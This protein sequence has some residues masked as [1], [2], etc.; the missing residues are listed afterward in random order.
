MRILVTI[1]ALLLL[2][3][4]A[5]PAPRPA[6]VSETSSPLRCSYGFG[7]S[8]EE[9]TLIDLDLVEIPVRDAV[10]AICDQAKR[11]YLVDDDVPASTRVTLHTRSVKLATALDVLTKL[12]GLQWAEETRDS[13]RLI[14]VG[15]NV[16][17]ASSY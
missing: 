10:K 15:K 4:V 6:R 9:D 2:T 3:S 13:K 5:Q 16:R 12:V 7:L 17:A 1:A 14:H 8:A 11:E